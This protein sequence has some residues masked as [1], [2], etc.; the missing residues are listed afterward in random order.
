MAVYILIALDNCKNL[1]AK[2]LKKINSHRSELTDAFIAQVNAVVANDVK[3]ERSKL[4]RDVMEQN[5]ALGIILHT[6]RYELL[7]KFTRRVHDN[8]KV[9]GSIFKICEKLPTE[10]TDI[11]L[12][13][14]NPESLIGAVL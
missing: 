4:V 13:R 1:N 10:I 12:D 5:N 14:I 6:P 8:K 9:T 3:F 11:E 2:I 7:F